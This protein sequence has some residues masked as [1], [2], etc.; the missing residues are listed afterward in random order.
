MELRNYRNIA[1]LQTLVQLFAHVV[2]PAKLFT[3][4][5][6]SVMASAPSNPAAGAR[7]QGRRAG[8]ARAAASMRAARHDATRAR[9]QPLRQTRSAR[10]APVGG[11]AAGRD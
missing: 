11:A 7:G 3:P 9:A 2:L 1:S 5:T 8:P 6:C 4:V 10:G